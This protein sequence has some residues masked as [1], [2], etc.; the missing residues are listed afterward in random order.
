MKMLKSLLIC[1]VCIAL[2]A[3]PVAAGNSG[4]TET[5]THWTVNGTIKSVPTR[6]LYEI[7]DVVSYRSMGLTENI[8]LIMD[9]E[10]D[11]EGNTY[12][13]TANS[14]ILSFDVNGNVVKIYTI[15]NAAG[16]EE[17]F[18]DAEGIY[19]VSANEFYIADTKGARVLH[20]VN[21]V[22]VYEYF[23]PE[24][25]LIPD[26]FTYQPSKV[27]LDSK[28]YLY[29]VSKGSYN[30]ALLYDD[31]GEFVGFYGANTVKGT[32]LTT[33]SYFWETLT[34]ND[35]KRA[36]MTKTLP[37][38]FSD[39]YVDNQ[40]FVY[41]CTG[42]NKDGNIGQMRR[43]SPGGTNILV[44]AESKNFGEPSLSIRLKIRLSQN[45]TLNRCF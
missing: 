22:V 43:L 29:V 8:G 10:C 5:F 9:I 27:A 6:P 19:V 26:D 28:G 38:D 40:D 37:Y 7:S 1:L 11:K 21:D 34:M 13:L 25:D 42:T 14:K 23:L 35:E 12:L 32:V 31:M 18:A 2:L 3:V 33:L 30:G 36:R 39:I 44:G 4:P 45:L 17:K 16:A 24:T 15:L 20:V 41:T